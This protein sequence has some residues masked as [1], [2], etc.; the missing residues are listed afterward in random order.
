MT[1]LNGIMSLL[2]DPKNIF[3]LTQKAVDFM[4]KIQ[5]KKNLFI[6]KFPTMQFM[7]QFS[8][9]R[10]FSKTTQNH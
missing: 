6:C 2:E 4:E 7:L 8:Q 5:M 3:S 9:K 10:D 1:K